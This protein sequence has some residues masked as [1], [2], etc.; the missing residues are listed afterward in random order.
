M[1][2]LTACMR[3]ETHILYNWLVTLGVHKE[4]GKFLTQSPNFLGSVLCSDSFILQKYLWRKHYDNEI[5]QEN[6]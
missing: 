2:I 4:L 6:I 3:Y 1:S 5:I